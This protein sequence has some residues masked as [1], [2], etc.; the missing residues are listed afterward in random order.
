MPRNLMTF[1]NLDRLS[2]RIYM[3]FLYRYQYT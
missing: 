1:I 2:M 3:V